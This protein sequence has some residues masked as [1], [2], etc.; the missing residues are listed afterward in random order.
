ME[1]KYCTH[2]K[3]AKHYTTEELREEF[4]LEKLFVTGEINMVYSHEDR[5]VIGG[6]V[7][8]S[9]L[10]LEAAAT[11]KTE[12]FL[13]R[14]EIG[15]INIGSQPAVVTIDGEEITVNAKDCLYIGLG[16]REVTFKSV[17]QNNPARLYFVSALAHKEYPTRKI[18]ISDATPVH[19]GD[20]SQSN[21]RTI[22]KFLHGDGVQTCQLMMGMT[23]LAPN[24]MWN[25]MPA[26]I[27]DRRNEVYLYFDLAEENRVMHFMGEPSETRHIVVANEQAIISPSWS[28]HSG[29]GTGNYTFIWAMAGE[30]YTFTDMDFVDM[31]DLK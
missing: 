5:V 9:E 22:Y 10:S 6:V 4:L 27:H 8:T 15:I 20:D 11:L 31:K 14:R 26:H 3:H 30:N 28:I 24:N 12:Y 18:D 7:P 13:E 2:P 17:D 16:K 21:K 19:L 23:F 25:T 29:V 1:I